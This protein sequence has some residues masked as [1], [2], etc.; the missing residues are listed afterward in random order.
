MLIDP[1]GAIVQKYRKIMPWCPIE[2]WYPGDKMFVTPGPKGLKIGLMICD[3]GNYPEARVP[4]SCSANACGACKRL[5]LHGR[6]MPGGGIAA[7]G[8]VR[9]GAGSADA[10]RRAQTWRELTM[11]GAELIVRCQ[12]Y[13][14]PAKEQQVLMSKCMAWSNCAYVAVA[15][16]SGWDGVCACPGGAPAG[17]AALR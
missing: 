1:T 11:K 9:L 5:R 6:R 8:A 7:G 10:W 4:S 13:M 3:D 2:G 16:A 15:N 14:Y 17:C 12:G